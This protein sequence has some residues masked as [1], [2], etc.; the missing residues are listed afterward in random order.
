[1]VKLAFTAALLAIGAAM[2][3]A[4]PVERAAT[5]PRVIS[6]GGR[7]QVVGVGQHNKGFNHTATFDKPSGK[8]T[9]GSMSSNLQLVSTRD[10]SRSDGQ[11]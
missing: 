4:V 9:L 6:N 5:Q 2:V 3:S 7:L 8:L 11:R 10:T 1:M